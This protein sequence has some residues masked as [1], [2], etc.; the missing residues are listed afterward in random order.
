[1]VEAVAQAI[2]HGALGEERRPAAAD[3]LEG[4]PPA[5]DVEIRVLL[6]RERRRRQIL[7]GRAG[8]HGVGGVLAESSERAR[9]RRRDVVGNRD[10]FDGLRESPR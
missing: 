9:D 1:M 8:S 5:R 3:V 10:P 6:A 7:R 2:R 4:S